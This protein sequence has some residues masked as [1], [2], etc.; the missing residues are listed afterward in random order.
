V[1]DVVLSG[2]DQYQRLSTAID[3]EDLALYRAARLAALKADRN[4]ANAVKRL[5]RAGYAVRAR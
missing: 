2:R 5:R 4:L 3:T 1:S